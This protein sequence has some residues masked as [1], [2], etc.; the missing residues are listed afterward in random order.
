MLY[1]TPNHP[2]IRRGGLELYALD[3]YEAVRDAGEYE[4]FLLAR[5]GPPFTSAEPQHPDAALSMAAGDPN[6]YLFANGI[7]ADLSNYDA[8]FGRVVDAQQSATVFAD[9]V[10]DVQPD[11]VHFQHTLFL[12]YDLIRVVRNTIP[13]APIVMSLHEYVPI[14]HRDGQM[15]RTIKEEL[16]QEESPRRCHECFPEVS[17]GEFYM[18]KRY[19]QSHLGLV[20]CFIAPSE[21]VKRRYAEWGLPPDIIEVEPQGFTP[22]G[23]RE[24][25]DETGRSVRNRFAF[26]GQLNPYKGADVLLRAMDILGEDFDGELHIYGGNLDMQDPRWQERFADLLEERPNVTFI[27]GYDREDLGKLMARM[28]WVVVPSI[29]WETGP[30][31]VWEAFQHGRPVICSDIG[32]MSEK[33]TD[34]VNGLHFRRG[35]ADHLA[36]IMLHAADTPGLWDQ[37]QRGIPDDAGHS[38]AGHVATISG[39]YRRLLAA[40][41]PG[42]DATATEAAH[43]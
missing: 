19:I 25:D 33:V 2:N 36:E 1:V 24:P 38:M 3:L 18:R 4:P 22:A 31:V 28:D 23:R 21:Y 20:D 5:T 10:R 17:T 40:R 9:F 35:D 30:L 29:W 15:V 37:L 16:C 14:C 11:V 13:A 6:Q 26:F 8:L 41:A 27:P 32:G 12:G 42:S 43:A 39:A 7:E 34:G